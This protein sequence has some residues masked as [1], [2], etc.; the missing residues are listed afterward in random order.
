MEQAGRLCAILL[1]G[2]TEDGKQRISGTD[3]NLLRTRLDF[4]ML[5]SIILR[6][7]STRKAELADLCSVLLPG[8]GSEYL[9]LV[10]RT[11]VGKTIPL[12]L[13][14]NLRMQ[15]YHAALRHRDPV[16][17]PVGVLAQWL[18]FRWEICGETPPDF[19][20]RESWYTTK[21]LPGKLSQAQKEISDDTQRN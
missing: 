1:R 21:V 14:G 13:G 6:E 16:L 9:G 10:L 4:L 18:I 20:R 5:Y 12:A 8:E 17:C 15:Y 3:L 7:K 11:S 19:R 2:G